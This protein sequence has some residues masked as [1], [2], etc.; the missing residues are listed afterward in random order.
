[1]SGLENHGD[2]NVEQEKEKI[3][4]LEKRK[5]E[6]ERSEFDIQGSG[7][8]SRLVNRTKLAIRL[9]EIRTWNFV[10][11]GV[12]ALSVIF[13]SMWIVQSSSYA[14]ENILM[15]FNNIFF[16]LGMISIITGIV[17]YLNTWKSKM[18][19]SEKLLLETIHYRAYTN[20]IELAKAKKMSVKE[21][22]ALVSLFIEQKKINGEINGDTIIIKSVRTPN[23]GICD[24]P[25]YEIA[26]N[27][28][29]CPFCK[30]PYHKDHLLEYFHRFE[31]KCPECAHPLDLKDIYKAK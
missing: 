5:I 28:L 26:V 19:V 13:M 1:M 6:L 3:V 11:S 9:K 30:R 25:I 14:F 20:I 16:Y 22:K 10:A 27:L 7:R 18:E 12:I 4:K 21:V 23:C 17:L 31:K 8:K 29:I 15:V 2:T 24:R